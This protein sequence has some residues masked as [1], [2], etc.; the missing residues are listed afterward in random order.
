MY[1]VI[2]LANSFPCS[3]R[4]NDATTSMV[5]EL[6]HD[7]YT[8]G[9]G[10]NNNNIAIYDGG[11]LPDTSQALN[12]ALMI[13]NSSTN[14]HLDHCVQLLQSYLCHYYFPTCHVNRN[15]IYPVCSSS[16]NLLI[17][18]D[19]CSDLLVTALHIIAEQNITLLPDD[20]LCVMTYRS[21]NG[22]ASL[23]VSSNCRSV[24]G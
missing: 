15:E 2:W 1:L 22:S 9:N 20:D 10:G 5:P 13:I 16:C 12:D 21:F 18:H 23:D 8:F 24:E 17:N 4:A 19:D 3:C 14:S 7:Y 11:I 6:C